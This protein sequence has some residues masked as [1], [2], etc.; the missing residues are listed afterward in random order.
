MDFSRPLLV[1]VAHPD[2][3]TFAL[4]GTVALA[5]K[6]G[7][8]VRVVCATRGEKG[9][10]NLPN[11]CSEQELG[12]MRANELTEALAFLG[13]QQPLVWDHGDGC[14]AQAD[15]EV[16]V[17]KLVNVI[18]E[19]KPSNIIT[20]GPDGVSG[21]KD[22]IAM[23]YFATEAFRRASQKN[24]QMRLFWI[25][26]PQKVREQF[27][28]HL[29]SRPRTQGHYHTELPN[30]PYDDK[31]LFAVDIQPVLDVKLQAVRAHVSQNPERFAQ[32]VATQAEE[33]WRYE[34]LYPVPASLIN[35]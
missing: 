6:A 5:V 35:R 2:D 18:E 33:F 8:P 22:H 27:Y 9:K 26:R 10:L 16:I 12:S 14:L 29:A 7:A 15:P 28:S 11:P 13:A 32:R 4:G 24:S 23:H 25:A 20:F 3:E 1:L 30:V 19:F 31:D 21:H 34:Y 17:E